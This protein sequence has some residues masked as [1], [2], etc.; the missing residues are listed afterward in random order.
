M[1]LLLRFFFHVQVAETHASPF[2]GFVSV[3]EGEHVPQLVDDID[4]TRFV[5]TVH[6]ESHVYTEVV[7]ASAVIEVLMRRFFLFC[8]SFFSSCSR[9]L[10]AFVISLL[11]AH[12]EIE[13]DHYGLLMSL[14][15]RLVD[16]MASQAIP[17]THS[18]NDSNDN[19]TAKSRACGLSEGCGG[20]ARDRS[21]SNARRDSHGDEEQGGKTVTSARVRIDSVTINLHDKS[22]A[23]HRS[24]EV[25]LKGTQTIAGG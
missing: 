22:E 12:A 9:F 21:G 16:D 13:K 5:Q 10:I 18:S 24:L 3:F 11:F 1:F 25:E 2:G 19:A 23:M 7:M 6:A 14:L 15:D 17:E 8:V 20:S 4:Y